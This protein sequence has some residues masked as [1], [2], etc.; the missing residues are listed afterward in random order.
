MDPLIPTTDD[1]A[2]IAKQTHLDFRGKFTFLINPTIKPPLQLFETEQ[3]LGLQNHPLTGR[4]LNNAEKANVQ[5][6]WNCYNYTKDMELS[7]EILAGFYDWYDQSRMSDKTV[8]FLR[9]NP[10]TAQA[11]N[12]VRYYMTITDLQSHFKHFDQNDANAEAYERVLATKTLYEKYV[13]GSWLLRHSS[14]NREGTALDK[15]LRKELGIHYYVIS[16][17]DN[18]FDIYHFLIQYQTGLGWIMPQYRPSPTFPCFT[19][20]LEAAL[21]RLKISYHKRIAHYVI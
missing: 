20:C 21:L 12:I 7:P 15:E 14:K 10:E 18:N 16:Y 13:K 1:Y 19:D 4:V 3:L 6:N 17:M 11:Y 9:I 2:E 8:D 5:F